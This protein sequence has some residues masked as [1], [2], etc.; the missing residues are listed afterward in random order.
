VVIRRLL[1]NEH[2]LNKVTLNLLATRKT[3]AVRLA[4]SHRRRE[5]CTLNHILSRCGVLTAACLAVAFSARAG[6]VSAGPDGVR[7]FRPYEIGLEAVASSALPYRDGPKVSAAFVHSSGTKFTVNGFWDGGKTWRLRFAP[8]LPGAWTWSSTSTDAGLNG[9]SG[10]FKAVKAGAQELKA[11]PLLHGFL[12]RANASWRLSDGTPFLAVG[13]THWAF[14]E[15][16]F[17]SEWNQWVGVLQQRGINTFLGCICLFKFGTRTGQIPFAEKSPK[18]DNLKVDFFQLLDRMVQYA[19]DRGIMM[20]LTIG[21]F[22][23]NSFDKQ[24]DYL[25]GNVYQNFGSAANLDRWFDY[26]VDRYAA[27]N[28][29]WC[30][31]GEVNEI[32]R[33]PWGETWQE[34]VAR[35]A[36]RVK[37]RDP[38]QH[39]IGSHHNNVDKSSASN[40][41]VDYFEVQIGRVE[42]QHVAAVEYRQYGKPVWFEEY[43]YEPA[44]YDNEVALGIRNTHRNFVAALAFPTF[45]SLMRSHFNDASF[46]P[47]NAPKAGLSIAQY[48]LSRDPGL[49]RM[50]YFANFYRELDI[51][52]FA[53]TTNLVN[54]GQCGRFG[55]DYAIFLQGGGSVTVNLAGAKGS[56]AVTKLDINTGKTSSLGTVSGGGPVTID[57]GT[58]SDVSLILRQRNAGFRTGKADKNVGGT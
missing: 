45:A 31:F 17:P 2:E 52:R 20:G 36:Q 15:E 37:D 3:G 49:D 26:C 10:K 33:T 30:L 13:D 28:V 34:V 23:D 48:L 14:S 9:V 8:T 21:G 27:Y 54:R 58:A 43:W 55:S 44:P 39:P 1:C 50:N 32:R 16:Y 24:F 7:T 22:P 42:T 53:V 47:T 5:A 40:P 46:V 6:L 56:F 19:N 25:T 51:L 29:R 4:V 11:N 35:Y 41:N 38:Y 12:V 18:T 57:S